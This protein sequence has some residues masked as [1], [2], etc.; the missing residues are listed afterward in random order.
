MPDRTNTPVKGRSRLR[1][2]L[3]LLTTAIVLAALFAYVDVSSVAATLIRTSPLFL[4]LAVVGEAL[5]A[6]VGCVRYQRVQARVSATDVSLW[7]STKI[8]WLTHFCAYFL[9]VNMAADGVRVVAAA[10]RFG[11]SAV[12]AF[13]GVVHDRTL[14]AV[15]LALCLLL[16]TPLQ[17]ALGVRDAVWLPQLGFAVA[18]LA[19][20]PW[21]GWL[22]RHSLVPSWAANVVRVLTRS[23]MHVASGRAALAQTMLAIMSSVCFALTVFCLARGMAIDLSLAEAIAFAPALYLAQTIPF[24]YGGFGARES[25]AVAILAGSGAMSAEA[26]VSLSLAVGACSLLVALPGALVGVDYAVNANVRPS[27]RSARFSA[28]RRPDD[29]DE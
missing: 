26:A 17:A 1:S 25:A 9:P 14:A 15:G 22:G 20:W 2:S 18:L 16:A 6:A 10:R 8:N 5:N 13:E 3:S 28:E 21:F 29:N 4:G 12:E 27:A 23:P 11:V 19:L 7:E 24:F